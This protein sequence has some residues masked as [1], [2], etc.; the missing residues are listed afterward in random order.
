MKKAKTIGVCFALFLVAG[1]ARQLAYFK[2]VEKSAG[3]RQFL[4]A[5]EVVKKHNDKYGERDRVLYHLDRGLLFF[6]AGD[7]DKAVEY[8]SIAE[9]EMDDLFTKSLSKQA[10]SLVTNEY[11]L[12]YP[13]LDYEQVLIN[14]FLAMAF[15][16][17]REY[18]EARV[19]SRKVNTKFG[20]LKEKN[21]KNKGIKDNG[22]VRYLSGVLYE[23]DG[24]LD[25]AYISY[26]N[27]AKAY[28]H[29][30]ATPVPA[31]LGGVLLA[32]AQK[33]GRTDDLDQLN[34]E[35]G[36]EPPPHAGLGKAEIVCVG[37]V[38]M[39]PKL[40]SK[41]YSGTFVDKDGKTHHLKFAIPDYAKVGSHS[42]GMAVSASGGAARANAELAED[43]RALCKND[44]EARM[45]KIIAKTA[46]RV[47]AKTVAG[48]KAKGK[49][50]GKKPVA[51]LL[52]GLTTDVLMD[53][54]EHADT[55]VCRLFAGQVFLARVPVEPGDYDVTVVNQTKSGSENFKIPG[56]NVKAGEKRFVFFTDLR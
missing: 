52:I 44:L 12:P 54:L 9:K 49:L 30:A 55:R 51:N 21:A 1:C 22:F 14:S 50:Y 26:Y 48:E 20:L 41:E 53:Q 18:D 46:A 5:A 32:L 28:R 4:Q 40:V 27:A 45:G 56:V 15:A 3:Q 36:P 33:T 31:S 16:G 43:T 25:N 35:Y 13:G 6:Y 37:F 10:A 19:E 24:D 39:G 2:K 42:R 47:L 8:L 17:R 29:E 11:V 23:Q 34:K 38:G 7:H